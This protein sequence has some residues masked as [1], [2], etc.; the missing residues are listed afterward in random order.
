MVSVYTFSLKVLVIN[1][2]SSISPLNGA[3]YESYSHQKPK[4]LFKK[5]H[6]TLYKTKKKAPFGA[7]FTGA[8]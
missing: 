3:F 1:Y 6:A 4:I 8:L 2:K 7:F 5:R